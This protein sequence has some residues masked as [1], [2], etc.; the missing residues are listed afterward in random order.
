MVPRVTYRIS[1]VIWDKVNKV[2]VIGS[3]L[4]LPVVRDYLR[5]NQRR[6]ADEPPVR[7][8]R[9]RVIGHREFIANWNKK[10]SERRV[11][12][13]ESGKINVRKAKM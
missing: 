8:A 12:K 6:L 5:S 11:G 10:K 3:T 7:Y 13:P 4:T 9:K 2:R 1:W